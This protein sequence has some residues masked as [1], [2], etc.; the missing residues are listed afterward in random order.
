[1]VGRLAGQPG[2]G[3]E[4]LGPDPG[5]KLIKQGVKLFKGF[6]FKRNHASTRVRAIA[7]LGRQAEPRGNRRF[8]RPGIGVLDRGGDFGR[9]AGTRASGAP[10][11]VGRV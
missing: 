4:R 3:A 5:A 2:G 10:A 6:K 11:P 7:N 8:Q 9:R 1:M